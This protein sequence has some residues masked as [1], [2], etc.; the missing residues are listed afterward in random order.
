MELAQGPCLKMTTGNGVFFSVGTGK[1]S[2]VLEPEYNG[3]RACNFG[4]VGG[5]C[6]DMVELC[7]MQ[8]SNACIY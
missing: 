5:G 1:L 6:C 8:M 3:N 4:T 7:R 2:T